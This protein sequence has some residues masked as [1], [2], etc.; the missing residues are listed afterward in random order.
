MTMKMQTK[1]TALLL[2][3][4]MLLVAVTTAQAAKQ[5]GF[6]Y[7]IV[8]GKAVITKYTGSASSLTIPSKLGKKTVTTIGSSAFARC[9]KLTSVVIPDSVTVIEDYAFKGCRNL[10]KVTLPDALTTIGFGAFEGCSSLTSITIPDTVTHIG[11]LAFHEC[12]KL[13][14]VITNAECA[15]QYFRG[16]GV[17]VGVFEGDFC[18]RTV[19]KE[20]VLLRYTGSAS[21]LTIP[22][23]L[24]KKPVT[25]IGSG[26]FSGCTR[27]TAVTIPDAV[28]AIGATAFKGCTSLKGITIP[29]GVTVIGESTFGG[30]TSLTGVT[31]P[32]SLTSIGFAAFEGCTSLTGIILPDTVTDIK[33]A[34]F[35]DCTSLTG[36]TLPDS[37]TFIDYDVFQGCTSLTGII[38]PGAVTSIAKDAF[39][40]C[41]GLTSVTIPNSVTS[42]DKDAFKNCTSLS[43]VI[44]NADAAMKYKWGTGVVVGLFEGDFC[45]KISGEQATIYRYT[46]SASE[47]TIPSVL[48]G[49]PVTA[50]DPAAFRGCS[51]LTRVVSN[52][53]VALKYNWGSGV[54]V[55]LFEGDFCYR[56]AGEQ[57]TLHRYTG[58]AA[59]V[60]IPSALGGKTVTV[61]GA[62]AFSGCTRLTAVTIPDTVATIKSAAFSG[63]TSLTKVV[64]NADAALK[65][66]WG[67]GV[68]V[69]LFEGDFCYRISGGQAA[70]RRYTGSAAD[71][72]I[73]SVLGGKT[74]TAIDASAFSGCTRMTAVT[75]PDSVISIGKDAFGGCTG[76]TRVNTACVAAQSYPWRTGVRVGVGGGSFSFIP[77]DDSAYCLMSYSGNASAVI[78][79][80]VYNGKPVTKIDSEAFS[81]SVT[82]FVTGRTP[83]V[84]ANPCWRYTVNADG[85]FCITGTNIAD[86][87][88]ILPAAAAG[89]AVT[90][91]GDHA[92]AEMA[93]TFVHIPDSIV[94]VGV[95]PFRR[96]EK[97]TTIV[98]TPENTGLHV[99]ADGALYSKADKRLV[100]FPAGLRASRL[101][102]PAGV[103]SIGAYALYGVQAAEIVLPDSVTSIGAYSFAQN[104]AL[105]SIVLP[106]GITE[107]PAYAFAKCTILGEIGFP[108]RLEHIGESAFYS[109][110]RL[111]RLYFPASLK[112]IGPWAFYGCDNLHSALLAEGAQTI[113]SSAF[114]VCGNLQT[115]SLP[116]SVTMIG[117]DAFADAP[118]VTL[119][120][121]PGSY[122]ASY[123]R[124]NL[125]HALYPDS[126][127]WLTE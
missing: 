55:G 6:E 120:V 44:S 46:G 78:V 95:N 122:A 100:C 118:L 43:V 74:V 36:V 86:K 11:A 3:V 61:I 66:N 16:S 28:T 58:L 33:S 71:V 50:I 98:V 32:D 84:A 77:V 107:I 80:S 109:C 7:K 113:G 117:A 125:L 35:K 110:D 83:F 105:M 26:A 115:V 96:C 87:R 57:A 39:A 2:T 85:T 103:Q 62:D 13:T 99:S 38:I 14:K 67:S 108:G 119:Y 52:A 89:T 81:K 42:I 76:L 111:E 68:L 102:I 60:T 25:S 92:F 20:A 97:L 54:L 21:S 17:L 56:I 41:T 8:N 93:M 5:N 114:A 24:G 116:A 75:I 72:T 63:C 48:G 15:F 9:T 73:P 4:L 1:L 40:D 69:G 106:G 19:G 18:Y 53:D 112:A 29:D 59:E 64:S 37:V 88:L 104:E 45:Y 70:L 22:S 127:S 94:T 123:A 51:N 34:A 23:K 82:L 47:V 31:L 49:K 101:T 124:E 79:P 121:Q 126:G 91:I 90:A 30:C 27:L 65:Y 12:D 10:T